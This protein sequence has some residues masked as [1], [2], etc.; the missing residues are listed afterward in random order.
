[1][2]VEQ[3]VN[4]CRRGFDHPEPLEAAPTATAAAPP[5]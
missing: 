3:L 4:G 1:L 5:L 2:T